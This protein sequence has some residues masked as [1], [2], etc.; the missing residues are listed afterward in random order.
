MAST[1][2]GSLPERLLELRG[3]ETREAIAERSG[4]FT[5]RALANWEKG[6]RDPR[7]KQVKALCE[8]YQVSADYLLGVDSNAVEEKIRRE[9]RE[10]VA[11]VQQVA[12]Q[13]KRT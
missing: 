10:L 13:L 8:V 12:N 4:K 9:T 5:S 1:S 7:A 2:T 6:K 11:R 3:K